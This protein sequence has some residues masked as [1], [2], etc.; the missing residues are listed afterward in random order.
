MFD[1]EP[2]LPDAPAHAWSADDYALGIFLETAAEQRLAVTPL[3]MEAGRRE[4]T[5]GGRVVLMTTD[6]SILEVSVAR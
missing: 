1:V 5:A 6:L 4:A 3:R 2:L